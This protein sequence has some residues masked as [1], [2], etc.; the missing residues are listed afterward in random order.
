MAE[1]GFFQTLSFGPEGWGP[2]LL[3]GALM[4]VAL[5]VSGFLLAGII[6]AL[7]AWAKISGNRP[8][9]CVAD[10]YTTVIRGI[11]DLLI[12]YLLYFGGSQALTS[13]G[14]LFGDGQF[15]SFP[16]F[17]AGML[18]VGIA[19]GAQQTEV[20]RGAFLTI[21]PGELEAAT[22]LGMTA[23]VRMRRI[24]IPLLLRHALPGMGNVWQLVLKAAALVSVTGLAELMNKAQTGAG[25]TGKPFDFYCAA[26]LLYLVI[27]ACS[28]W[29]LGKAETYYSRGV[30]R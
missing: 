10:I 7:F 24:I 28:G 12:I 15:I 20:F 2:M 27:S 23:S 1:L 22:S 14:R 17:L 25:S 19:A 3:S 13:L 30:R 16:G 4:T 5:A 8:V 29:S 11:P 21:A 6:G 26:A 18:A 9:R